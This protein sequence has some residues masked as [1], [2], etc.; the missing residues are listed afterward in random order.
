MAATADLSDLKPVY[1]IFGD[2]DLLLEQAVRRLRKRLQAVADLDFN[3]ETFDGE[4]ADV[5]EV[6]AAANTL[7]FMSDRRLVI[8]RN[9][10]KLPSSALAELAEYAANPAQ[11]TCLVLVA[12]KIARNTKLFKAVDALKGTFEYRAPRRH[13]YPG[14]VAEFFKARGRTVTPDGAELLVASVGRD[15]RRLSIEVDNIVSWSEGT[16]PLTAQ[17]VADVIS[18]TAPVSVFDFTDAVGGR[19]AGSA[20]RLLATLLVQGESP[21]GVHAMAVRHARQLLSARALLDRG[22]NSGAIAREMGMPEWLAGRIVNQAKRFTTSELVDALRGAADA[23][24]RMKTSQAD[25]RL[26]LER[27]VLEVCGA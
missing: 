15:L 17:D 14:K 25:A 1:L 6:V 12:R 3:M 22:G 27:W 20:L 26:V 24:W 11:T 9:A 8:V 7:P 21:Q 5:G 23:E 19:D 18:Q 4:N 10:D 2:E 16:G 13:E